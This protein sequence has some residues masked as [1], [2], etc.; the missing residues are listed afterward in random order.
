MIE[1]IK[2]YRSKGLLLDTNLF[3]L[4]V[5]GLIKRK[6]VEENKRT[7]AYTCEDFDILLEFIGKFQKIVVTP[8]ILAETSNLTDV[9]N[10][11]LKAAPFLILKKLLED[12]QFTEEIM[13]S[14]EIIQTAGFI[15]YGLTDSGLVELAIG[16][17]LILTDDLKVA[18][19]AY[20]KSADIINFNHI[21]ELVWSQQ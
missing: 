11:Q 17:Y 8:H 3:V 20:E 7:S 2:K 14:L 1:L 16:K 9:F 15:Q 5:I 18:N 13:P 21:R 6:E 19:Y 10:K 4:L 12:G